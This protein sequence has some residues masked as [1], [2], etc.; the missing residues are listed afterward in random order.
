[1]PEDAEKTTVNL[2]D[3]AR[4]DT[5]TICNAIDLFEVRSP[6]AGYMN[7][8]IRCC[9]EKL[10]PMVGYAATFTYQASAAPAGS[11]SRQVAD[12]IETFADMPGPAVV[13]IQDLDTP[14]VAASFGEVSCHTYRAFGAAGLISSGAGRDLEQVEQINF[15][16]FVGSPAIC[17]HGY[18]R[19]VSINEAVKVGGLTIHPGDLLHGD[20]NGVAVIPRQIAPKVARVA[21]ELLEAEKVVLNCVDDP[22]GPTLSA[23]RQAVAEMSGM[24]ARIK[25]RT[26]SQRQ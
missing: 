14:T 19:V 13:V 22:A 21:A 17:S 1:M 6:D 16:V 23:Y 25:G 15:P 2:D 3:L 18:N 7:H 20:R 24:L 8:T 10:P 11:P 9:F 12:L 26:A 5:P 4:Y